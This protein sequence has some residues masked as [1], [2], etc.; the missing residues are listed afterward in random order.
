M[1]GWGVTLLLVGRIAFQ[2]KDR[3]LLKA[4]LYGLTA[5]LVVE[6]IF[7]AYLGVWP[8]VGVDVAVLGLFSVPLIMSLKKNP[9]NR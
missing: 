3:A 1:I 7:S 9:N 6:A 2:R 4:L 5:W 8:N